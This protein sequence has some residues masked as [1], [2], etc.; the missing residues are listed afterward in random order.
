VEDSPK[1]KRIKIAPN[2][3]KVGDVYRYRRG[4]DE[5][6]LGFFKTDAQAI[7]AK[8]AH[9]ALRQ[10]IGAEAFRV[11]LKHVWPKYIDEREDQ[12]LGKLKGRKKLS[13]ATLKE[14]TSIWDKHLI[15][16][17]GNKHFSDVDDPLWARYVEQASV[18]H[19]NNHRKVLGGFLRWAKKRGMTRVLPEFEIPEVDVRK[20]PILTPDQMRSLIHAAEGKA[21][22][23]ISLYLF[24]GMRRSEQMHLKWASVDFE[25]RQ[26]YVH[27]E[28]TRTRKGRP[29]PLNDTL[30]RLLAETQADQ[31]ARG[32]KT[33]YVYPMR[34]NPKRHMRADGISKT[35]HTTLKRAGLEGLI[36][37]HDLRATFETYANKR[38]EFTDM[39][40]EKMVGASTRVQGK[41]YVSFSADDV[42]GLEDSIA[43]AGLDTALER[44]TMPANSRGPDGKK[45]GKGRT[46]KP[47]KTGKADE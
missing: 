5:K 32:I 24:I 2:L 45:T 16:F 30:L 6:V 41:H 22:L 7:K 39:Q 46:T 42:R 8:D 25:N 15:Q 38:S 43:F 13:P 36:E 10:A 21:L 31:R 27:D 1:P 44:R 28:T 11:R 18:S 20:R 4:D 35:W 33:P 26:T 23:F 3:Y 9:A 37:P 17:F 14:M 19:L 47:A 12:V 34:G 40:R 29:V